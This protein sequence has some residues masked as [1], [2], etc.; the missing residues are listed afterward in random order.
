M[1]ETSWPGLLSSL[2]AELPCGTDLEYDPAFMLL[3]ARVSP[4]SDAQYGGFHASP[5]PTNWTEVERDCMG[6]LA[7]SRDIRL[8]V[9]L[10]RCHC[11]SAGARGLRNGL[12]SLYALLATFPTEVHPQ[13][14]VDGEY[15]PAVRANALAALADPAGLMSEIRALTFGDRALRVSMREIERA[16]SVPLPVDTMAPA[17][18]QLRLDAL[19]DRHA[20]SLAAI[21]DA[22]AQVM[23]IQRWCV[24]TMPGHAP[25]LDPLVRLLRLVSHPG[26]AAVASLDEPGARAVASAPTVLPASSLAGAS[27]RHAARCQI[28]GVRQWLETHEPSSPVALLLRQA[29]YLLGKPFSEVFQA[30]PAELVERWSRAEA[31]EEK[32]EKDERQ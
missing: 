16:W 32:E 29:E 1:S 31:E 6:L 22:C 4:R 14:Q 18:V 2:S 25:D 10:I 23:A 5:E 17:T 30:I 12:H 8:V 27:D 26:H 21:D 20:A 13:L 3:Q 19:R 24:D 15:D 9:L 11:R 28:H 7:R